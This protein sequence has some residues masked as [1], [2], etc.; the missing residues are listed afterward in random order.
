MY[1]K[2]L[3]KLIETFTSGTFNSE[4]ELLDE[5]QK[6]LI[7]TSDT[8]IIGGRIWKI[9]VTKHSY[10][11]IKQNGRMPKIEK[12][13]TIPISKY[14][15]LSLFENERTIL[16][17]ETLHEL[18]EKGIFRYAATGVGNKISIKNKRYYEYLLAFNSTTLDQEFRYSLDIIAAV[19][20]SKIKEWRTNQKKHVLQ[21]DLDKARELQKSILPQ[22]ELEF[23][24][25]E[26][27]G[28]TV[29]AEIVGGDFFDYI[30]YNEDPD[31]VGIALGDAASK[32]VAA[33]AEAMYISGALRMASSLEI[34]IAPMFRKLNQLT[35]K[36][37][38]D[39][40]FTSLFYGELFKQQNGLFIYASAGHNPP[41]FYR[42]DSGTISTLDVTG[43]VL[44][45]APKMNYNVSN[46]NFSK[47]DIL[48]I[49]SDGLLD[50]T[51]DKYEAFE[52]ER[53]I[54]VL[55]Q[56]AR[57]SAK[58]IAVKIIESV[59]TY[60]F[61]GSYNDDK[62]VVVIKKGNAKVTRQA[63]K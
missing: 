4:N 59:V 32:G 45:P 14:P 7:K 47:G 26:V 60:S 56:N 55:V 28:V 5:V 16:G 8:S 63:K 29:P 44:G 11:L 23:D 54:E 6:M 1:Y 43:P 35:H 33:A 30:T 58:E 31:R 40:K 53:L 38:G 62:T 52:E 24:D 27:Y 48:V 51:N 13:F 25:Y 15:V 34:K 41:L 10:R 46:I 9:D 20:T 2:H 22:H 36:I 21:E 49:F 50:S 19:L 17:N 12:D 42:S 37:F 18:I 39:E 57:R 3:N 61:N